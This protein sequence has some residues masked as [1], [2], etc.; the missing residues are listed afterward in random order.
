[1]KKYNFDSIKMRGEATSALAAEEFVKELQ[2][3]NEK[4]S[5]SPKPLSSKDE[6]AVSGRNAF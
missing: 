5:Y 4:G 3:Y 6:T 2:L 1:M